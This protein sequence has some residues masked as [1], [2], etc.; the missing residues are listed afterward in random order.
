MCHAG[1][2]YFSIMLLYTHSNL[3]LLK[4]TNATSCHHLGFSHLAIV[5]IHCTQSPRTHHIPQGQPRVSWQLGYS[6]ARG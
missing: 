5:T 6:G 1:S 2:F 4:G 3:V